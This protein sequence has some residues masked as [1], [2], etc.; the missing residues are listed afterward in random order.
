M[1]GCG[2][3]GGGGG[4]DDSSRV[5]GAVT[6]EFDGFMSHDVHPTSLSIRHEY[7]IF[8]AALLVC[9]FIAPHPSPAINPFLLLIYFLSR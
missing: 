6:I 4:C 9:Y 1:G 2:G 5:L 7:M 3:T 8:V